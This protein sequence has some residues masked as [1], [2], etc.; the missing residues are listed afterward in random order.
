M[1]HCTGGVVHG[2]DLLQSATSASL[3]GTGGVG[4]GRLLSVLWFFSLLSGVGGGSA[5]LQRRRGLLRLWRLL[6]V[7]S[8]IGCL[9]RVCGRRTA[10]AESTTATEAAAVKSAS[11]CFC[12]ACSCGRGEEELPPIEAAPLLSAFAYETAIGTDDDAVGDAA[13]PPPPPLLDSVGVTVCTPLLDTYG[14]V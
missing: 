2:S 12:S 1:L 4:D 14:F 9:A 6:G 11:S 7:D 5:R 13:E 8:A 3:S 10:G